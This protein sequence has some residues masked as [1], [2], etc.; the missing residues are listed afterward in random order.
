MVFGNV[1]IFK[2][3]GFSVQKFAF[4]GYT[5]G[6]WGSGLHSGSL[7]NSEINV[8]LKRAGSYGWVPGI[9]HVLAAIIEASLHWHRCSSQKLWLRD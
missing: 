9:A 6:F 3:L 5:G 7:G 2:V 1:W 4:E 8:N